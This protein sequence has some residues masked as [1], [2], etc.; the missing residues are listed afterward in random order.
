MTSSA[1]G[2][3]TLCGFVL[4]FLLP[5]TGSAIAQAL[6]EG[7]QS[8][9]TSL[10]P[11]AG[12]VHVTPAGDVVYFD[13]VALWRQ[14]TAP[15]PQLLLRL[16]TF[17]F[18]SFTISVGAN[19]VLF[20]ENSTGAIWR[21]PLAGPPP[22]APL[23]SIAFNY[24]AVLLGPGT[25]LVSARTGGFTAPQ[26]E[27]FVVD[28]DTGVRRV[29]ARLPGPSGPIAMASNGDLYYATA[30]LAFPTPP[31]GT[32]ILRIVRATL[33][34]AI[35][36]RRQLGLADTQTAWTGLDAAA[37]LCF[38]DDGDLL[39]TDWMNNTIGELNDVSGPTPW[40]GAP[41]VGY[42]A[43]P[44]AATLQFTSG[45]SAGVFEPFQ[46]PGGV[47]HVHETDYFSTSSLRTLRAERALLSAPAAMP[48][49]AGSF[50]VQI[51]GGP[52]H[53]I[54]LVAIGAGTPGTEQPFAV[55]GFEQPLVWNGASGPPVWVPVTLDSA[56]AATL[57][58]SNPGFVPTLLATVQAALVSPDGAL[59]S[60]N[61]VAL[62]LGT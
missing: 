23:C 25:A 38:D 35:A 48:I 47:L 39:F 3:C 19:H 26:S 62:Q 28:L 29:L 9:S 43:L 58:L 51:A 40:L 44:G 1:R 56:G 8:H 61:A 42:G 50:P 13:G 24:D 36:H 59:G 7:L 16:P 49:V 31:G 27:I 34:H 6:P 33:D 32:S 57:S 55:T 54:G 41:L 10:P 60:S 12:A 22:T 11:T 15:Q 17:A 20:G 4:S 53:G 46:P 52:A 45:A 18:W 2:A 30:S 14:S 37:D 5:V 21:V